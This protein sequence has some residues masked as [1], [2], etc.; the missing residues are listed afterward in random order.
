MWG[1]VGRCG[2]DEQSGEDLNRHRDGLLCDGGAEG[3][4]VA[5]GNVLCARAEG[6][7]IRLGRGG[8]GSGRADG[9]GGCTGICRGCRVRPARRALCDVSDTSPLHAFLQVPVRPAPE[10]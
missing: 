3:V 10:V 4:F 9:G 7:E 1:D 5:R 2:G 6:A 8:R